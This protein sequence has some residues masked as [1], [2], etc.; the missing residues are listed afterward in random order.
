AFDQP[1][2][3]KFD[4][5]DDPVAF[6]RRFDA[7]SRQAC[8]A[9]IGGHGH[10]RGAVPA[11][12]G[13]DTN[14]ALLLQAYRRTMPPVI[15][16]ELQAAE[17]AMRKWRVLRML[18]PAVKKDDGPVP[19]D[20]DQ[21]PRRRRRGK[22]TPRDARAREVVEGAEADDNW[23]QAIVPLLYRVARLGLG[24]DGEAERCRSGLTLR[25]VV[26]T[27]HQ[28][29]VRQL[30]VPDVAS[31]LD[32][33]GRLP[34]VCRVL[35]Y[36]C[37][38]L[39][40]AR[41]NLGVE[42][43]ARLVDRI[44]D[45]FAAIVDAIARTMPGIRSIGINSYRHDGTN[46]LLRPEAWR[47]EHLYLNEGLLGHQEP[48]QL[49]ANPL[50]SVE[51]LHVRP[52]WSF[53]IGIVL[54]GSRA[55]LRKL[56]MNLYLADAER[57][58]NSS[59][60]ADGG[61]PNLESVTTEGHER[62]QGPQDDL[63][64]SWVFRLLA[65]CP[66]LRTVRIQGSSFSLQQKMC[67]S[68]RLPPSVQS[69]DLNCFSVTIDQAMAIFGACPQLQ[70]AK[71]WL[72][73]YRPSAGQGHKAKRKGKAEQ[74]PKPVREDLTAAVVSERRARYA[75]HAPN[76]RHLVL[77][78]VVVADNS[79]ASDLVL[80]L[81]SLLPSIARVELPRKMLGQPRSQSEQAAAGFLEHLQQARERPPFSDV[82]HLRD[83]DF[84]LAPRSW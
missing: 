43:T 12:A 60:L 79:W 75:G 63:A 5:K 20:L 3:L 70:V 17:A 48:V 64:L 33:C 4:V 74:K 56:H 24:K 27:G 72:G 37:P 25:E 14:S 46:S 53:P 9:A 42:G 15:Q 62:R 34:R 41:G 66:R 19:M 58:L 44:K 22:K 52:C 82:A 80:M 26:A 61:F 1:A 71:I 73:V 11:H 78:Q 84:C 29:G 18:A 39:R 2:A 30:V 23:Y 68:I 35:F 31:L 54:R 7:L 21:L 10:K 69:L 59:V 77:Y 57:L 83:I 81:A 32:N 55:R 76:I 49:Q 65:N 47:I 16:A 8:H 36:I 67:D 28:Q 13:Y 40:P 6:K 51:V 38:E 45:G 50:P